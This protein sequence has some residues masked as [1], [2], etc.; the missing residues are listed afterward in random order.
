MHA[1]RHSI[2]TLTRT[3]AAATSQPQASATYA[4]SSISRGAAYFTPAQATAAPV[5]ITPGVKKRW[6]GW[7]GWADGAGNRLAR[8]RRSMWPVPQLGNSKT[9]LD[10]TGWPS[11]LCSTPF[12]SRFAQTARL[13]GYASKAVNSAVSGLAYVGA[14]VAGGGEALPTW[15]CC[16]L[17]EIRSHACLRCS[18]AL[19]REVFRVGIVLL[20]SAC[21]WLTSW[22]TNLVCLM[23]P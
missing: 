6:V 2:S 1:C 9:G 19:Q 20:I 21:P 22:L 15:I 13:A 8:F 10:Q 7:V 5:S 14:K 11:H 4:S 3:A 23:L 18:A 12:T 16:V 17:G